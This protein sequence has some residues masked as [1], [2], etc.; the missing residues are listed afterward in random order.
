MGNYGSKYSILHMYFTAM[1]TG[2]PMAFTVLHG[3]LQK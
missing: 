1:L 3:E 2:Y